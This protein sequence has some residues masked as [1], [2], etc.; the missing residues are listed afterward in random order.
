[1]TWCTRTAAGIA[2]WLPWCWTQADSLGPRRAPKRHDRHVSWSRTPRWLEVVQRACDGTQPGGG[3]TLPRFAGHRGVLTRHVA[4]LANRVPAGRLGVGW[5][6]GSCEEALELTRPSGGAVAQ[7]VHRSRPAWPER[8]V[9]SAA[10]TDAM[11]VPSPGPVLRE[12]RPGR[13]GVRRTRRIPACRPRW[14]PGGCRQQG[15]PTRHPCACRPLLGEV[16]R[17]TTTIRCCDV[18]PWCIRTSRSWQSRAVTAQHARRVA[19]VQT[20]IKQHHK[21][22]TNT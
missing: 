5:R 7:R 21:S 10:R 15:R 20:G 16:H 3:A 1:M 19:T 9:D 2:R 13:C 8:L 14:P 4:A 18:R 17:A 22:P 11:W 6:A 12:G